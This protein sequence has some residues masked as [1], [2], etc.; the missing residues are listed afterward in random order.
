MIELLP[1]PVSPREATNALVELNLT[2]L[3]PPPP[4]LVPVIVKT[5]D[6]SVE[7]IAARVGYADGL[8][9]SCASAVSPWAGNQKKRC[10]TRLIVQK[11]FA[12]EKAAFY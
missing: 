4:N 1:I 11:D 10:L 12:I 5:T 6:E 7:E 8:T 3:L 9:L 2:A